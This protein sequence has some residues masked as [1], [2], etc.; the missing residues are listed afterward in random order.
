MRVIVREKMVKETNMNLIEVEE[1]Y[2]V[3][4]GKRSG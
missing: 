4:F 1:R 2:L 3:I